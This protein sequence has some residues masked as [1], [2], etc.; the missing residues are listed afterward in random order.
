MNRL[1]IRA[2]LLLMMS[3]K[4]SFAGRDCGEAYE[5]SSREMLQP[6]LHCSI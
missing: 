3:G 1:A 5:D 6:T 4:V 2:S